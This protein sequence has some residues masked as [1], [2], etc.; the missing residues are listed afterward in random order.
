MQPLSRKRAPRA[1]LG[2]W[3]AAALFAAAPARGDVPRMTTALGY[4]TS[5]LYAEQFVDGALREKGMGKFHSGA[6]WFDLTFLL[7]SHLTLGLRTH[8]LRAELGD[9][10]DV[11]RFDLVPL[12]FVV[13]YRRPA[14]V[15]R[16][17]G[18]VALGAGVATARF[19]PA[20]TVDRWLPWGRDAIGVTR[21]RPGAI[22]V[23]AGTAFA[24][25][26]AFS[27]EL[28]ATSSFVDTRVAFKPAPVDESGFTPGRAYRVK[29]RH[30]SASLALRWWVD[31]L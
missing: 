31:F 18:F 3:F 7:P 13:G 14:I 19:R 1:L 12:T 17:G 10:T 26:E 2:A 27:V 16:L 15:G 22:E 11:G 4:G 6:Y 21:S 30:L 29:G 23:S 5:G 8:T 20:P 24:L 28:A 9:G 25:S